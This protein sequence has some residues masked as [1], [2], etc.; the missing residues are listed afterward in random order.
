MT[1]LQARQGD[2]QPFLSQYFG[3]QYSRF[4][5]LVCLMMHA[6]WPRRE[7]RRSAQ[8]PA[9]PHANLIGPAKCPAVAIGCRPRIVRAKASPSIDPAMMISLSTKSKVSLPIAS[10]AEAA[11]PTVSTR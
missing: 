6:L 3:I 8:F 7:L 11:S 5:A 1:T 10:S 2:N 4:K 9:K